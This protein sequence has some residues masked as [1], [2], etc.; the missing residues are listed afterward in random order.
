MISRYCT[1]VGIASDCDDNIAFRNGRD[2]P[3]EHLFYEYGV[4][5]GIYGHEHNVSFSIIS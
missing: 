3:L 4:D 5:L 2:Y 1:N